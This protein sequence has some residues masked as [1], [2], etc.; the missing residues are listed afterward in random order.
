MARKYKTKNIGK[1]S[2][3]ITQRFN[4]SEYKD[5]YIEQSLGLPYHTSKHA[6]DFNSVDHYNEAISNI[7]K[8]IKNPY[9][10]KYD[11]KRKSLKYYGKTEQ[12][13]CVVVNILEKHAYVSTMY[14]V[15]KKKIDKMKI[16]K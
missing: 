7:D 9:Y 4:I 12:Y 16:K 3:E 8:V 13:I 15:N 5:F 11:K 1:I 14:P 2:K 10:V 6:N